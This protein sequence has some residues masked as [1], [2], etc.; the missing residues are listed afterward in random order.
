MSELAWNP[1]TVDD[2]VW[3]EGFMRHDRLYEVRAVKRLRADG[4]MAIMRFKVDPEELA[5][6]RACAELARALLSAQRVLDAAAV[7]VSA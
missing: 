5:N 4:F 1:P 2:L 6:K 3:W 7:E